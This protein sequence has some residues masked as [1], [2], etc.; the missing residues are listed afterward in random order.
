[1]RKIVR[2]ALAC[3]LALVCSAAALAAGIIAAWFGA[4]LIKVAAVCCG[5]VLSIEL[6]LI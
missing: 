3:G 1:M 2:A 4:S 5:T 6:F